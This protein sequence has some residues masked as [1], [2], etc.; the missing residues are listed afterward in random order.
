MNNVNY[1]AEAAVL[2]TILIDGTL[3]Q[4]LEVQEE[5]FYFTKHKRIYQAMKQAIVK[6]KFIDLVM[7]TTM[8]GDEIK[9]VGGTTYLLE[10][11]ESVASTASLKQ[12]EQLLFDAYRRRLSLS[13]VKKYTDEPSDEALDILLKELESYRDIGAFY[14]EKS[15]RDHLLEISKELSNPSP[16]ELGYKTTLS[17]FDLMT[18]GLQKGDLIIIAARPSVGKTAF[19]LNLAAGHCKNRGRSIIFSLEMGVKQL[20]RRMISAEAMLDGS[21][22]RKIHSV[23]SAEDYE[24]AISA[25]GLLSTWKLEIIDTKRTIAAIRSTIRKRYH[26]NPK[27]NQLVIIDYLQLITPTTNRKERRDLEI[28]E[29]TRELKLL[30]V[31]LQIPII[32]LSQ[33]SRG[34]ESRNNKRPLMSDLRESGNIEQDAD[35]ITFLYR[36]DYYD[37]QSGKA[38][39]VEVNIA[40]HRNGP[41]G[42]VELKFRK[43]FGRFGEL[44]EG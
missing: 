24:H 38:N 19:A 36:D 39:I 26:D 44:G 2:G 3:F 31:E 25:I 7:V 1:E 29:I 11:A 16:E 33:L 28:G 5:Q 21:K 8:L 30:A 23:F 15:T 42:T 43:E 34:V 17:S 13:A 6:R 14:E 12:H 10:M 4:T 27:E 40:K 18:G 20:L 37:R 9:Q 32:L 35:L 22:W 41:T